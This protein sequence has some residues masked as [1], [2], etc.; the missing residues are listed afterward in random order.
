VHEKAVSKKHKGILKDNLV[1]L[2]P[3]IRQTYNSFEKL[4]LA[5]QLYLLK[6]DELLVE[7]EP[8]L[9]TLYKYQSSVIKVLRED[10]RNLQVKTIISTCQNCTIDSASTLDHILPK[11]KFPEFI[12]NPKNLFPCCSTCNS[13]KLDSFS[14]DSNQKFL[15]LYLD[16]LPDES[17]LFVD[18]FLDKDEEFNFKYYLDN[19]EN[20]I[21][22]D[23]F[24]IIENHYEKLHLFDRLRLKSIEHIS[25]F[26]NRI[27]LFRKRLT[28]AEIVFD[29]MNAVEE[30]RKA[31]GFNHWKSALELALLDSKLFNDR[32]EKRI[33]KV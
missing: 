1:K 12:V 13:Y 2:H 23:L 6:P 33:K 28:M 26:E 24:L 29:F 4:F 25:E 15:N 21:N 7:S 31:Y 3:Q 16:E 17:Y 18:V 8:D 19:T 10:I 32:I 9:K 27:T 30:D 20:K 14:T 11:A 5:N 22:A